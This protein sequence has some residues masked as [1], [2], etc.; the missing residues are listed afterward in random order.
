MGSYFIFAFRNSIH[1]AQTKQQQSKI[2]L[3]IYSF[4][5]IKKGVSYASPSNCPTTFNIPNIFLILQS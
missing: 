3:F 2:L 1:P 4:Q 5:T